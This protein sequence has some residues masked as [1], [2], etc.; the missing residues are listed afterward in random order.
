MN[1]PW[2]RAAGQSGIPCSF[3]VDAKGR[4][5]WIGHPMSMDKPLEEIVAGTWDIAAAL[6]VQEA[7]LAA[8]AFTIKLRSAQMEAKTS[9]DWTTVL[10]M[11]DEMI[12]SDPTSAS[13]RIAAMKILAG[14]GKNPEKAW[15]L[16][17]EALVLAKDEPQLLNQIAWTICASDTFETRA[18]Q[19]ALAAAEL[20]VA[21]SKGE[22]NPA[23]LDTCARCL[24]MSGKKDAAIAM[25]REAAKLSKD[26]PMGEGIN[27]VLAQYESGETPKAEVVP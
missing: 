27:E 1:A 20:T 17:R 5:A 15:K 8:R 19:L 11:L 3:I 26:T 9:G 23:Y 14:P 18:M 24:W 16:G 13:A 7:A 22:P 4:V 12:A 25:Q 10:G 21:G 2:M 6:K